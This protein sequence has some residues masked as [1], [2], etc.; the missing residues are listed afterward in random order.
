MVHL[1]AVR[2][3]RSLSAW[4][5]AS[6]YQPMAFHHSSDALTSVSVYSGEEGQMHAIRAS[7]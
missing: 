3:T 7:F 6:K 1:N 5:L 4:Y 2:V